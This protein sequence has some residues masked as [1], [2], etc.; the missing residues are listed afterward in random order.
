MH[1]ALASLPRAID[2]TSTIESPSTIIA[3]SSHRNSRPTRKTAPV[4]PSPLVS[5]PAGKI[6]SL[7]PFRGKFQNGR[8]LNGSPELVQM[9][10][11]SR[12]MT[13]TSRSLPPRRHPDTS[14]EYEGDN[15][16]RLAQEIDAALDKT[17]W[18]R[19]GSFPRIAQ[20][21]CHCV[22]RARHAR[23]SGGGLEDLIARR[24]DLGGKGWNTRWN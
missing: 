19:H 24:V 22:A 23:M 16:S 2:P 12:V 1:G 9:S 18:A 14:V 4:E 3:P 6:R 8:A 13:A 15:A 17:D 21:R 7:R 20:G 11:T 5:T 10:R